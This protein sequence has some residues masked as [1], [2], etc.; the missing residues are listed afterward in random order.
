MLSTRNGE[1]EEYKLLAVANLDTPA[2]VFSD[3]RARLDS[4]T[5]PEYSVQPPI[6]INVFIKNEYRGDYQHHSYH[7][8][9]AQLLREE[10]NAVHSCGKGL[11]HTKGACGSHGDILKGN[12]VYGV[13]DD[14]GEKSKP[15]HQGY[16]A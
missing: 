6:I 10:H 13:G 3:A 2:P 16:V 4:F 12:R 1:T 15:Q 7:K 14:T 9:N 8:G 11:Y 5:A